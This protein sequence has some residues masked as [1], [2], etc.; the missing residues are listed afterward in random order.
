MS[1][2]TAKVCIIILIGTTIIGDSL[3]KW[4]GWCSISQ[5]VR[6]MDVASGYWLRWILVGMILH[7]FAPPPFG[8]WEMLPALPH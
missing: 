8:G 6:D 1:T 7:W 4:F 2:F 3:A 5:M